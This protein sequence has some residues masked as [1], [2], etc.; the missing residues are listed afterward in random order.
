MGKRRTRKGSLRRK[1]SV[2]RK[3]PQALGLDYKRSKLIALEK[4]YKF[5]I[6]SPGMCK[7]LDSKGGVIDTFEYEPRIFSCQ[8]RPNDD[9]DERGGLKLKSLVRS[10]PYAELIYKINKLNKS[11]HL[12]EDPE[13]FSK[14]IVKKIKEI[15]KIKLSENTIKFIVEFILDPNKD[16]NKYKKEYK[17]RELNKLLDTLDTISYQLYNR[18]TPFDK[19]KEF[20]LKETIETI[21]EELG[22]IRSSTQHSNKNRHY[23]STSWDPFGRHGQREERRGGRFYDEIK[24]Y[25]EEPKYIRRISEKFEE[26]R[27]Y[28]FKEKYMMEAIDELIEE[29]ERNLYCHFN[30][31]RLLPFVLRCMEQMTPSVYKP[32][33]IKQYKKYWGGYDFK[34]ALCIWF[35]TNKNDPGNS[36][37]QDYLSEHNKNMIMDTI[38]SPS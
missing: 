18:I 3:V 20:N 30:E 37:L 2:G 16:T 28:H 1:R 17:N 23:E 21:K 12:Y 36:K 26:N 7:C 24:R 15:K 25:I 38:V 22:K 33:E 13:A 5:K 8:E 4:C 10:D 29:Q 34:D 19:S 14:D 9:S 11:H 27:Q 31:D 6:D 35:K 32:D